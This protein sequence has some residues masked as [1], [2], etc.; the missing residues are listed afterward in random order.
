M[1]LVTRRALTHE[2]AEAANLR[3]TVGLDL[4]QLRDPSAVVVAEGARRDTGKQHTRDM[5]DS[6]SLL[7]TPVFETVYRVRH[8]E[9]LPLRTPFRKVGQRVREIVE[10]LDRIAEDQDRRLVVNVIADRTGLG[11]P[12][13]EE[14]REELGTKVPVCGV[15]ITVGEQVVGSLGSIEARVPKAHLVTRLAALLQQGG[16]ELPASPEARLLADE[17]KSFQ[18]RAT[19]RGLRA[20][21]ESGAHDDLVVALALAVVFDPHLQRARATGFRLFR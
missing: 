1:D 2:D 11:L 16:I 18:I 3:V 6:H 20:E 15:V 13:V 5:G 4:G 17:L 19:T 14:L 12:T 8:V 7:V 9:R 21:A 10:G